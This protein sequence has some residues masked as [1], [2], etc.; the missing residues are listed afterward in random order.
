M[1]SIILPSAPR[2]CAMS[3]TFCEMNTNFT[4]SFRPIRT[5][6]SI[7]DIAPGILVSSQPSSTT[8]IFWRDSGIFTT[9]F[10]ILF[11]TSRSTSISCGLPVAPFSDIIVR[12]VIRGLAL[13][14]LGERALDQVLQ[15]RPGAVANN[16]VQ[17]VH[18]AHLVG[19]LEKFVGDCLVF[20]FCLR[21][22]CKDGGGVCG[23]ED[24]ERIDSQLLVACNHHAAQPV[25]A[26]VAVVLVHR[27]QHEHRGAVPGLVCIQQPL[28]EAPYEYLGRKRLAAARRADYGHVAVGAARDVVYGGARQSPCCIRAA[29]RLAALSSPRRQTGTR[30]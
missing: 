20:F 9:K 22:A 13:H 11:S 18:R 23:L 6:C 5:I 26:A 15:V 28:D 19:V 25:V 17:L 3:S 29:R 24:L 2:S 7:Y 4:F 30:C 27:V 8:I 14:Y 1:L 21:D 10:H 16:P 12:S